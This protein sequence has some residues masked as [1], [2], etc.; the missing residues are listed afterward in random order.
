MIDSRNFPIAKTI[1]AA[2]VSLELNG[3]RELHW[4][5]NV[6]FSPLIN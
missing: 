6:G 3:L 1:A 4:H 5:L 2:V